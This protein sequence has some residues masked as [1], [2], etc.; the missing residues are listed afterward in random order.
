[1]TRWPTTG[2]MPVLS[3][4]YWP[5]LSQE[6]FK[7]E[8]MY[9]TMNIQATHR[10]LTPHC[11]IIDSGTLTVNEWATKDGRL[12]CTLRTA[13]YSG[14][15]CYPEYQWVLSLDGETI[16][17]TNKLQIEDIYKAFADYLNGIP[18]SRNTFTTPS[19][20]SGESFYRSA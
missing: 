5:G 17:I 14:F 4:Y 7:T 13:P 9:T 12:H 18:V 11:I 1:M 15:R 6:R 8:G 2:L 10:A 16:A 3:R 19:E 20:H